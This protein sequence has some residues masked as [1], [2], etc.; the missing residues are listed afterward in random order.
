MCH[1]CTHYRALNK[2]TVKDKF[3]ILV[4]DELLDENDGAKV[5]SKLHLPSAYQ[6]MRVIHQMFTRLYLEDTRDHYDS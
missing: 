6:Q 3:C 4:T 5:S 1:M 2:K